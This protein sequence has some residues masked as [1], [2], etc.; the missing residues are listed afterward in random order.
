M[1]KFDKQGKF[2]ENHKQAEIAQIRGYMKTNTRKQDE[3][4]K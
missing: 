3:M 4:P 1:N 2:G